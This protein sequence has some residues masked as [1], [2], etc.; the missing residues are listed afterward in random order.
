MLFNLEVLKNKR[1]LF[2]FTK[3][4]SL[5]MIQRLISLGKVWYLYYKTSPTQNGFINKYI[6]ICSYLFINLSLSSCAPSLI[7]LLGYISA[8]GSNWNFFMSLQAPNLGMYLGIGSVRGVHSE[9]PI[10]YCTIFLGYS[11]FGTW[12]L[13]IEYHAEN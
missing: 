4:L 7:W 1:S 8:S 12:I 3:Y 11:I 2:S 6:Y 5:Q 9:H 10:P 13:S